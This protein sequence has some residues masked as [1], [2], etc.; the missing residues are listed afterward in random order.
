M[1]TTSNRPTFAL[2]DPQEE[3]KKEKGEK[4]NNG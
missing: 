3:E 1:G 2:Y 4:K